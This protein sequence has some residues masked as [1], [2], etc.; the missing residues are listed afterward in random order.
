MQGERKVSC[1]TIFALILLHDENHPL[2]CPAISWR[3]AINVNFSHDIILLPHQFSRRPPLDHLN[4]LLLPPR[5]FLFPTQR[6]C[7]CNQGSE[8]SQRNHR[9][10]HA[11][12]QASRPSTLG[13]HGGRH[14]NVST[15]GC[16]TS[17]RPSACQS[18]SDCRVV[19]GVAA[20]GS[21]SGLIDPSAEGRA[22]VDAGP[23]RRL[24]YDPDAGPPCQG[25][26]E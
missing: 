13:I 26:S 5:V 11:S 20:V 23:C 8:Y 14:R 3:P 15:R 17:R 21:E 12:L 18:R 6:P 2:G 4:S 16:L 22:A 9:S 7:Q 24:P 19:G 1:K 25:T 10:A